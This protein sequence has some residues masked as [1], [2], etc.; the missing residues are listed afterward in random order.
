MRFYKTTHVSKGSNLEKAL[1]SSAKEAEK[2]YKEN[3]QNYEKCYVN[4]HDREWFSEQQR[5][6]MP[7]KPTKET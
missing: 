7:V 5:K 3:T 2:V 1:E 6:N 4:A